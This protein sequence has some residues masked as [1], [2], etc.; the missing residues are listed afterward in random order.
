MMG[1]HMLT[2]PTIVVDIENIWKYIM[3]Y[4]PLTVKQHTKNYT[5][6]GFTS[7]F[8]FLVLAGIT[9]RNTWDKIMGQ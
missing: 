9:H 5:S 6:D 8:T 2:S 1:L 3:D 7:W 4:N